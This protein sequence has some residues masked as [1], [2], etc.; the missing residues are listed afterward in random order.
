M[1]L[2]LSCRSQTAIV[3]CAHRF[4]R[5]R[6][7]VRVDRVH[8]RRP[9]APVLRGRRR[10]RQCSSAETHAHRTREANVRWIVVE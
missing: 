10:G 6:R 2:M 5:V 4:P 8:E 1:A 3:C 7:R 9:A